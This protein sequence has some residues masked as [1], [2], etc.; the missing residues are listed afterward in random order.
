MVWK[1]NRRR[2]FKGF[3]IFIYSSTDPTG[4][5]KET[6][7]PTKVLLRS[8]DSGTNDTPTSTELTRSMPKNLLR[9]TIH[10][11]GVSF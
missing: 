4:S 2:G 5:N 1:V 10:Y 7:P 9:I 11:T 3:E 6:I 8:A